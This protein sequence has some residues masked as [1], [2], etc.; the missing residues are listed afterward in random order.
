MI[1][2]MNGHARTWLQTGR[3]IDGVDRQTDRQTDRQKEKERRSE[4]LHPDYRKRNW[5]TITFTLCLSIS[6]VQ[7]RL[8]DVYPVLFLQACG[9]QITEIE[10]EREWR[11][12]ELRLLALHRQKWRRFW[13]QARCQGQEYLQLEKRG[14]REKKVVLLLSGNQWWRLSTIVRFSIL[15]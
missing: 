3:Q 1:T 12:V 9:Y 11:K 2:T 6:N 4:T 7:P 8:L 10:R 5:V 13:Y 15:G 14:G